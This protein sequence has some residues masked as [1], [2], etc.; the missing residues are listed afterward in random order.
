MGRRAVGKFPNMSRNLSQ[1]CDSG[2]GRQVSDPD[3]DPSWV[4]SVR[5]G[6]VAWYRDSQRILPWRETNDPYRILVSEMMLVQTTVTAVVAYFERFLDRFP[7]VQTL[8][9][10][11]EVD[12]LRVGRAGLLSP[13]QAASSRGPS[14]C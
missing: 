3:L 8:A 5:V 4:Q 1:R 13:C 12:V 11:A 10:A 2:N 14:N 7:D 6:L 9:N